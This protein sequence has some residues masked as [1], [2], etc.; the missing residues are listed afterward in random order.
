MWLCLPAGTWCVAMLRIWEPRQSGRARA[1]PHAADCWTSYK[2]RTRIINSLTDIKYL[3]RMSSN[4]KTNP[5]P[6]LFLY[7]QR[8]C[9]LRWCCPHGGCRPC[10][11]KQW[12]CRGTVAST[13]TP[14]WTVAWTRS[15]C[16]SIMSAAGQCHIAAP[17]VKT[18]G[19]QVLDEHDT[20]SNMDVNH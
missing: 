6:Y 18:L 19:L 13:I 4:C 2:V 16:S 11:G 3:L 17:T 14:S 15:L 8:T 12:S 1:Q 9:L 10:C 7:L 20:A 5:L